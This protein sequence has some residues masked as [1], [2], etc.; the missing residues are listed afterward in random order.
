MSETL[1]RK[2]INTE[3][4]ED[5]CEKCG[6][7]VYNVLVGDEVYRHCEDCGFGIQQ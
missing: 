2:E 5:I 7:D 1:E 6:G 3:D 4:V